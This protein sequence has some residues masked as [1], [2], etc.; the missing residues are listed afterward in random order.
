MTGGCCGW[1]VCLR[2]NTGI[3][4]DA[5]LIPCIT[6]CLLHL[7]LVNI[8]F[9][10]H[11]GLRQEGLGRNTKKRIKMHNPEVIKFPAPECRLSH[12]SYRWRDGEDIPCRWLVDTHPFNTK[13]GGM[14]KLHLIGYY[15]HFFVGLFIFCF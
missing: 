6:L 2:A 4:P 3:I 9:S 11:V 15:L 8:L 14:A 7:L 13:V 1:V 5:V 12:G 10:C